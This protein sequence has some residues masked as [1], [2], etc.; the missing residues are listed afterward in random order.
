MKENYDNNFSDIKIKLN[1]LNI[2]TILN[3]L[4]LNII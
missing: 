4:F 3:Y 2:I 1:S